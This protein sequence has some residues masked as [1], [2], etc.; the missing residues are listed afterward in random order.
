MTPSACDKPAF[1]TMEVCGSLT[2]SLRE[3]GCEQSLLSRTDGSASF[4]QGNA[5]FRNH[6]SGRLFAS[7][8]DVKDGERLGK[9]TCHFS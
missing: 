2:V 9:L 3:F 8:L 5:N 4:V 6:L 1:S 7:K